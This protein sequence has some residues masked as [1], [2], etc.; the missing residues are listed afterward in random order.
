MSTNQTERLRAEATAKLISLEPVSAVRP[1]EELLHELQ[2]H[3]IE[4]EMQNENLRQT[5]LA[6]EESRDRY[7]DLYDFAPVSYFTL[8][9][10][11]LILEANFTFAALLGLE[12]QK[13][14]KGRFAEFIATVDR[15]RWYSF[16]QDVLKDDRPHQNE[17][18]L[19]RADGQILFAH[20]DGL[21]IA[22][23][24]GGY[25][26]RI[27]LTDITDRCRAE[28]LLRESEEKFHAI[29]ERTLDGGVLIDDTGMIIDC[30]PA[31]VQ[32]SG[33]TL[34]QLKQIRIWELRP[35]NKAELTKKIFFE[36]MKTGAGVSADIRFKRPDG[37]VI[38]VGVRGA[39]ISIS[40]KCYMQ[41]ITHDITERWQVEEI[42]R[43]SAQKNRLLF[44]N[45]RDAL[46]TF[47][48]PSWRFTSANEA[49]LKLFGASGIAELIALTFW[50]VSPERQ[51]DGR[52]SSEK[53]QEMTELAMRAG[54]HSFEW[55]HQRLDG[56]TFFADV[57]LARMD[58]ANEPFVQATVRDIT[59]RKRTET[60]LMEYQQ[61]L[62]ELAA[63]AVASREAELKHI[64][65][66]VHDEL[67]QLL[68]ALRMDISLLRI[69]FGERDPALMIKIQ[70]MLVLVDKAIGGVRDVARNLRPPA[71]DMGIGFALTWLRD[72]FA[73]RTD[74]PCTL[75]VV[76]EPAGLDDA[77]IVALFRIVQESLTNIVRYAEATHVEITVGQRG[78]GID[79]EIRDNGLGFDLDAVS[80]KKSFGLMGMKERA[81]AV[82]GR[83]KINSMPMTGTV[84]SVHVPLCQTHPGRRIDD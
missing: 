77:S 6:L 58:L 21:R 65:R 18:T 40:G 8:S 49:T 22:K 29:F 24:N 59:E 75:R 47:A 17:L 72:E 64:A 81:I 36:A 55:E 54:S 19:Q 23:D 57:L 9:R 11:G 56:Q 67:G 84:V 48:P 79:V 2:M 1:A 26:I 4:L 37:K 62:R 35:D 83:V 15:G 63:Q 52:L 43:I 42:A 44:E 7:L 34:D 33:M 5:Q 74:I 28:T 66:E 13:L 30:N 69:Q 78:D 20:V 14:R 51:P 68:T 41:C 60:E 38:Y 31:F 61:L 73:A 46:M 71:L 12:R 25:Q 45:S 32:Q 3:Q 16:F 27:V 70:D 76:D 10:E 39:S 53:A 50:D 80:G 82:C